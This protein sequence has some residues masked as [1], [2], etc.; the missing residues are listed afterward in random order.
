MNVLFTSVEAA[1]FAKAGGM[2][3]VVGSLP[4]ALRKLGID[5]RV[6]MPGA[7]FISHAKYNIRPLFEFNFTHNT[8]TSL[9]KLFTTEHQ[10]VPIYFVQS[11]PYIGQ[12]R[13]V[14]QDLSQ[15]YPR[16]IFFSKVVQAV[17]HEL[18][19]RLKW[20]A[21]IF[22]AHDWHTGLVPFLLESSRWQQ[23]WQHIG[24]LLTIHNIGYQGD[25]AG[26]FLY[27]QGIAPR[28]DPRLWNGS[29]DNNLMAIGVNYADFVTTVSPRYAVEIQYPE[30]GYGL[31]GLV[32]ARGTDMRGILNGIDMDYWNPATDP[33]IASHFD[34]D[35]WE[36]HRAA[37]KTA[38]QKRLGLPERPDVPVLGLVSRLSGQKGIDL[39]LPAMEGALQLHDIQFVALGSG[40]DQFE[41]GLWR[42]ASMFPEKCRFENAFAE[43]LAHQIYAGTDMFLM[44]SHFEPCGTSQMLAMHYGSLPVVRET[45]GLADTVQNYDN[46]AADYGTGFTFLWAQP[47]A[48][49]NTVRWAVETYH[50]RPEAW[51]RMMQRAMQVDF[52]WDV[53]ARQYSD[54]YDE[55]KAR[56]T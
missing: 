41:Y 19:T 50:N 51:S 23:E 18:R 46:A 28:M 31:E 44:P 32:R 45:G 37:N 1:P 33:M 55:A 35:T 49:Y 2:A 54:L 14:Y 26:P 36:I 52:S 3:D 15:D 38:L 25:Y 48:L 40:E 7:G 30:N 29:K 17:A 43:D 13:G 4:A 27:E 8:G 42:L 22:H 53:S 12:E 9:V 47:Y 11:W 16:M 34:A 5:A 21:D 39:L 24:S 20:E 6:L 56:H 10:G